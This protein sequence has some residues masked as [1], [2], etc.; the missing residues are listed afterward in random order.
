M[1]CFQHLDFQVIWYRHVVLNSVEGSQDQIEHAHRISV[2]KYMSQKYKQGSASN[3]LLKRIAF[4]NYN[5]ITY[6]FFFQIS[7]GWQIIGQKCTFGSNLYLS[8]DKIKKIN[9]GRKSAILNIC[10]SYLHS[11][12]DIRHNKVNNGHK[13]AILSWIEFTF[14]GAYTSLKPHILL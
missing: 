1:K 11:F 2:K 14:F 6:D 12:S 4:E 10:F 7:H 3:N 8:T 5:L 9:N 13:F